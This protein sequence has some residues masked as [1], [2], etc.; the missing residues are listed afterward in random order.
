LQENKNFYNFWAQYFYNGNKAS[1]FKL[2]FV[3]G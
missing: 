2:T 3:D 1:N